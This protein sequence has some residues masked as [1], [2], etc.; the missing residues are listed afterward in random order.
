MAAIGAS[1][2]LACSVTATR[3]QT[4]EFGVWYSDHDFYA[5]HVRKWAS[6]I[7]QRTHGRVKIN[8]HFSH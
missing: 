7:E 8:L 6:E 2:A 5:Q 3:A 1:F 4:F